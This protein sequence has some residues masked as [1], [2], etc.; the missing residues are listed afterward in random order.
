MVIA[1][2]QSR[3]AWVEAIDARMLDTAAVL[4]DTVQRTTSGQRR[5]SNGGL[6][7][8]MLLRGRGVAPVRGGRPGLLGRR[9]L[10]FPEPVVHVVRQREVGVHYVEH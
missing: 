1:S 3:H 8:C 4:V 10:Q 6:H 9:R 5:C 2:M 7:L